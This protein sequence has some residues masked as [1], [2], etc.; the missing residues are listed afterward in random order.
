M[1]HIQS[2]S[3]P[4]KNNSLSKYYNNDIFNVEITSLY[5][6]QQRLRTSAKGV[7]YALGSYSST[8]YD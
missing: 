7:Q 3:I 2:G 6:D 8:P 5:L 1:M 4:L